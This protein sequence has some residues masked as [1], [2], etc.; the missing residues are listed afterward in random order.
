MT[1][2]HGWAMFAMGQ[3]TVYGLAYL[4]IF[5]GESNKGRAAIGL[6]VVAVVLWAAMF[7]LDT[8][9]QRSRAAASPHDSPQEAP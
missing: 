7:W 5:E 6:F 1:T 9:A 8:H 3:A 4:G 2:L